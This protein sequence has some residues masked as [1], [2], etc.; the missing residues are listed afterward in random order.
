MKHVPW[1]SV[2]VACSVAG[3]AHAEFKDGNKL[4]SEMNGN[5][6]QQM[7]A[8]GYVVGVADT[9][10]TMTICAPNSIT[11]G[12]IHDMVKQFLVENPGVR[13]YS[14]DSIVNRV[15]SKA[16]PCVKSRGQSL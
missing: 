11:A 13:H 12:Q 3:G 4:L 5:A 15:L 6:Y 14:G 2:L 1:A 9:L 16:W 7:T 10:D 8:L